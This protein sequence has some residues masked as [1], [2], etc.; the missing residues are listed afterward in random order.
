MKFRFA[1]ILAVALVTTSI[2]TA[3]PVELGGMKSTPPKDWVAEK[4]TNEMRLAQFKLP[5]AEGDKEDAELVV[6]FFKMGSGSEDDNLAR[7]LK[8]FEPNEG[9]EK[10]ETKVSKMKVGDKD[11]TVQDLRGTYLSKAAPFDPKSKVTKRTDYRQLYVIFKSDAG[12]FYF[13]LNGPIKTIE[14]HEKP[15][16]EFLKNF[17]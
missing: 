16:T 15:F 2:L 7:Q 6:F 17:K 4:T 12:E 5:K 10:V 3:D 13:R 1:G 9:K 11:C 14:K 8:N